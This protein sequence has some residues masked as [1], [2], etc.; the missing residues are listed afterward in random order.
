MYDIEEVELIFMDFEDGMEKSI[1]NYKSE[2]QAIRVG[3][4]NTHILDKILVDFY[5][6]PSPINQMASVTV[7]EARLLVI[8]PWDKSTLK[9]IEKAILAANIGI[10]P[11]NDGNV[12]RLIFP[13]LTEERR[14]DL[15][16]DIKKLGENTKVALRNQRRD[17]I[18]S[19]KKLEKDSQIT[20]DDLEIFLSDVD[21][22]LAGKIEVVDKMMKDKE[23]DVMAV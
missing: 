5:G 13:E 4:A 6:T 3:R 10:T 23:T 16:K 19:L 9:N 15:V 12:I 21:K 22:K 20:E 18:D 7:A 14:R 2:L 1:S 11:N 8:N 17:A